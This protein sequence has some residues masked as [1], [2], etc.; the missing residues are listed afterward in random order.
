MGC[1]M[2]S[3]YLE[4]LSVISG[5]MSIVDW[6]ENSDYDEL[7]EID[8]NADRYRIVAFVT[9][10]SA[11]APNEG[12]FTQLCQ[13][14][15][16][17]LV[18]PEDAARYRAFVDGQTLQKRL[19]ESSV[20]GVI[21]GNFRFM[22]RNG[23]WRWVELCFIG[24]GAHGFE[25]GVVR[26]Y[27]FD[28]QAQK[29][30]VPER[31]DSRTGQRKL[32]RNDRTNLLW[33]QSFFIEAQRRLDE[34]DASEWCLIAIDID[35]FTLFN[36]WYGRDI[37]DALLERV[38]EEL[39]VAERVSTGV[40]GYLGQD[41]FCLVAPYNTDRMANLYNRLSGIMGELTSTIG[42]KPIFGVCIAD[43]DT[44]ILD[45]LDRAK[46]ALGYAENDFKTDICLYESEMFERDESEYR[47]L[48]DFQ[49]GLAENEFDI[50]LQPQCRISSGKIVGV[51]A[52]V[53]W[54]KPDGSIVAP[55]DFIP[56]LEKHGFIT[57][58]DCYVW[59]QLCS[60]LHNW[61]SEGRTPI[62]ASVNVS[63]D[64]F[65]NIDVADYFIQL[66]KQYEI[67]TSLLKIEITESAIAEDSE[68]V[69]EA[70]RQLREAGFVV[71]M[72]DFGSGY[73][74]LNK[75][76]SLNVDVIKLDAGFFRMDEQGERKGIRIV[77]SIVNMAKTM[78]L[79]II[80]EGVETQEQ[81][82]FLDSLGCRYIQGYYFYRPMPV[83][84]FEELIGD[85]TRLDERGFDMKLNEQMRLREF[86][87]QNV[88][89]DAMLNNILGPVAF[90]LWRGDSVDII[91]FNEQFYEAVGVPDFN[92]RLSAIEQF[93][94]A[95]DVPKLFDLFERATK[96]SLNGAQ[97]IIGFYRTD[98]SLSRFMMH[99][100]YLGEND[101]GKRF[102]GSVRDVTEITELQIELQLISERLS[103]SILF[104][105][106]QGDGW[107][108]KVIIHGLENELGLTPNQFQAELNSGAFLSRIHGEDHKRI[109]AVARKSTHSGNDF[110]S[111]LTLE[112]GRGE[113]V[114]LNLEADRVKDSSG[115]ASYI[116]KLT[117]L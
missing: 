48:L 62:P 50:Y 102:Y 42:F 106:W 21:A 32:Y 16:D 15:V 91:R 104:M 39:G 23:S 67:P 114:Q 4:T 29:N 78:A 99:V 72:D 111:T 47:V 65:Y 41:D 92:T 7:V 85:G 60:N 57:D 71:L 81:I 55:V 25:P 49:Q 12:R 69:I 113:A 109:T 28:I 13:F 43:N 105:R 117:V 90:Y 44:P 95:N 89:S 19:E 17:H 45:L 88:Y 82:D 27:A 56:V 112:N 115:D 52:L 74:S 76:G 94:P 103:T 107:H 46:I 93:S 14:T 98:G 31:V 11:N 24:N 66:V 54:I 100:Y 110:H 83:S 97:D 37:G 77:E 70:I 73:S 61:I 26:L 96:D 2:K 40:A 87:D 80:C 68:L 59:E 9:D 84:E 34:V 64:D 79:P 38:G 20:S 5:D 36:D 58:L 53:R 6:L 18:N 10:K 1:C 8:L 108:F 35:H 3:D 116:V 86:L 51:E 33:E 75:L 22:A 63:Q 101:E 30:R